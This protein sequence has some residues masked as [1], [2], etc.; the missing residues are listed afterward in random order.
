MKY[1]LFNDVEVLVDVKSP[2]S[3]C[4]LRFQLFVVTTSPN[5]P[6]SQHAKRLIKLPFMQ[7]GFFFSW[8]KA[9]LRLS[10]F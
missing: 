9:L 6:L 10:R 8:L 3:Q 1:V 4:Q 7:R 2:S 5:F